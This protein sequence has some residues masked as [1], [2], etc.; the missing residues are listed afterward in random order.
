MITTILQQIN[1][2]SKNLAR[3]TYENKT[4]AKNN[5]HFGRLPLE[6][7][8]LECIHLACARILFCYTETRTD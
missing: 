1:F 5:E 4:R 2:V 7:I 8:H 6:C 3:R